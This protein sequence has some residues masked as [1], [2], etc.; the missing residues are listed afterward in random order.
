MRSFEIHPGFRINDKRMNVEQLCH[1]AFNLIKDGE[2]YQKDLGELLLQL[3]D[4]KKYVVLRTSGTT[5]EPKEIK[6]RKKAMYNSAKATGK[7][8]KLIAG[9]RALLCL[10]TRYIGGKMMVVRSI[11]LGLEL[12][13]VEPSSRPLQ[14]N[15][16][17]YDFVPMV[18]MQVEE[19][20]DE[21]KNIKKIII[22][23]AQVNS[24]LA[25]KLKTVNT[26]V[27]ET[28]G[29]TETVSHIAAKTIQETSFRLL[30]GVK[31]FLDD[32]SCL[33]IDAPKIANE[34]II[35]NDVVEMSDPDHGG[36]IIELIKEKKAKKREAQE[37]IK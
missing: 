21:L 14:G 22:G 35:T 11:V 20:L 2:P 15:T 33:V 16:K 9:D 25:V 36:A 29:M 19:S 27:Y 6:I 3:F 30:P 4:N 5:G 34:L 18:P 26:E 12:D 32:R 10:P 7:F 8:F 31:A 23:G 28:Y 1:M 13:I 24:A 37:Q 17:I